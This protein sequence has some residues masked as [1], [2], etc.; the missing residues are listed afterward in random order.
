MAKG[1]RQCPNPSLSR[2]AVLIG[3]PQAK[4]DLKAIGVSASE[5][6]SPIC[7][8]SEPLSWEETGE[9]TS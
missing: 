6:N 7:F 1:V 9:I 2:Q 5:E 4:A 8:H 3:L